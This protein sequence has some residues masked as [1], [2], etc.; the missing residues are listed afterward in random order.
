MVGLTIGTDRD[1]NPE[2]ARRSIEELQ[3]LTA[4]DDR[5][6]V[7]RSVT[8]VEVARREKKL[9]IE[10]NFQGTRLLGGS[11]EVLSEFAELGVRHVGLIWNEANEAGSS[12]TRGPDNGLTA[13]GKSLIHRMEREGI[14]VDGAHASERTTMDAI[15]CCQKPFVISHTNCHALEPS[16]KNVKDHQIEACARTGGVLGISG[17]GTYLGDSQATTESLFRHI[18]H[19]AQLVGPKHVGLGL[20]F[21]TKPDVFWQMVLQAPSIWPGKNGGSMSPCRFASHEQLSELATTLHVHGYSAEDVDG[22]MGANWFRVAR[23]CWKS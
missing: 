16:Y 13:H 23:A 17:F 11:L 2:P 12:S 20:D 15:A 22:I 4:V 10:L 9:G 7:I 3:S 21:V 5:F 1:D 6:M 14:I 18:D 19:V 8:E